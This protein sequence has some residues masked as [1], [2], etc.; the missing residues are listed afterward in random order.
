MRG[1]GRKAALGRKNGSGGVIEKASV[2]SFLAENFIVKTT[3]RCKYRLQI[4]F[5]VLE[6]AIT[7]RYN[8]VKISA[9]Q[10]K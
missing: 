4:N 10:S 8:L 7:I 9:Y 2:G 1:A 3:I 5:A 6:I